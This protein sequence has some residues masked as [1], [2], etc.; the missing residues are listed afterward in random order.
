MN[1]KEKLRNEQSEVRGKAS[2]GTIFY[3]ENTMPVTTSFKQHGM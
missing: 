2:N 1:G 3:S